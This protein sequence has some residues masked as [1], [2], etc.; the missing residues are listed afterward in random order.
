M[1]NTKNPE[2]Q[3]FSGFFVCKNRLKFHAFCTCFFFFLHKSAI[4]SCGRLRTMIHYITRE[5]D[6]T[7]RRICRLG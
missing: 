3:A 2:K 1:I 7:G 4:S 5:H 6:N